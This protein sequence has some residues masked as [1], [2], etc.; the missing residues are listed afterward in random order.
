MTMELAG[1]VETV[2]RMKGPFFLARVALRVQFSFDH[3]E[4]L[5]EAHT[6]HFVDVC[7]EL[8]FDPTVS[9]GSGGRAP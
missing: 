3:A 7:R 8:G 4:G 6:R 1:I 5:D 2:R 9:T